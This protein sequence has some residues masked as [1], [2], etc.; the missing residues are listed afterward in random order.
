LKEELSAFAEEEKSLDVQLEET[1]VSLTEENAVMDRLNRS[2]GAQVC[3]KARLHFFQ[4][5]YFLIIFISFL[6]ICC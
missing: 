3:I 6:D 5:K 1:R 4:E 2:I